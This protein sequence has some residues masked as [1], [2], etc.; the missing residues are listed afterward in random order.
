MPEGGSDVRPPPEIL[1][2]LRGRF[3]ASEVAPPVR[4]GFARHGEIRLAFQVF[5]Q[6]APTLFLLPGWQMAHSRVW[7]FQVPYLARWFRLVTFDARGSGRSDRPATGYDHDTLTADALAVMEAAEVDRAAVIGWSGGANHAIM[8]AADHPDRVSHL[9]LISGAPSQ[10]V[11]AERERRREEVLR[12]FHEVRERYAGWAKLNANYFRADYLGWVEFFAAQMLP[13]PHSTKALA[14]A[15]SWG[16]DG[17]PEILIRTRDEWWS[18]T[19]FPDLMGRIRTP[20]LLV[21]GTEDRLAAHAVNAPFMQRT[22][23]GSTLVTL[24]GTGHA[25]I[26]RECV[27]VNRLIRDFVGIPPAPRRSAHALTAKRKILWVCSPIGL[28]HVQRDLA[29]AR[30]LRRLRPGL[31]IHWLTVDPVR[32]VVEQAGEIVHPAS[33]RLLNESAH[34]E[35]QAGEHDVNVFL[36]L[37]QMDEVLTSNFMTFADVTE[38]ERYDAWVGDEAWDVDYFLHENP[39]LKTAPYVFLTDYIGMLPIAGWDS[40]EGH[41]CWHANAEHVGHVG[42]YPRLRDVAIFLGDPEDVLDE[43]FGRDLPNMRAWAREHFEFCDYILPF[44]PETLPPA[45]VLRRQLGYP[46]DATLVIATAGGTSV[47][48]HL[49]GKVAEAGSSLARTIP[50]LRLVVV[51]GP[52]ARVSTDGGGHV[53]VQGY[54]P[55]LYQ[56][57]ACCDAA[58]AQG[59]LTTGMELI[60]LRRPFLSFPLRNHFEQRFHVARRLRR[61]GHAAQMDYQEVSPEGLAEGVRRALAAPIEYSPVASGGAA[62]AAELVARVLG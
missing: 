51:A 20:T 28:G 34:I 50:N 9:V 44:D 43:P 2:R 8:L 40:Y 3:G 48:R 22:I 26:L 54:L 47:G 62:R 56:H 1:D 36:A 15:M 24:E 18:R 25:G 57:L 35:A 46:E 5:G 41:L 31:E 29:I 12:L 53:D 4:E 39:E 21:H 42:R 19:P 33:D 11:G 17:D 23:A 14:D 32:S 13:E 37:W 59:G 45:P 7:K 61:Y 16:L 60:A 6:A 38:G 30:E 52:R 27:R 55:D 58:V 10:A 49:L